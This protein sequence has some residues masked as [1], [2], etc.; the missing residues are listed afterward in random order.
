MLK[1]DHLI[2]NFISTNSCNSGSIK[3]NHLI[4]LEELLTHSPVYRDST[5]YHHDQIPN[6]GEYIHS[7]VLRYQY[8]NHLDIPPARALPLEPLSLPTRVAHHTTSCHLLT[9]TNI[10]EH[11]PLKLLTKLTLFLSY[12][13]LRQYNNIT[14]QQRHKR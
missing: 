7:A 5:L 13:F 3:K 11:Y 1:K 2:T 14:R 9:S 10:A 4:R 6:P 12:I 8:G